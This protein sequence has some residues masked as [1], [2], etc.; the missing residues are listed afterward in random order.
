LHSPQHFF[1][2]GLR[3]HSEVDLQLRITLS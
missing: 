1:H 3:K 2:S